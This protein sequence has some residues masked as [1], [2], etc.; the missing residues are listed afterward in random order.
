M[1][2]FLFEKCFP[3][4][5]PLKGL[6]AGA[7]GGKMKR[8]Q[9]FLGVFLAGLFLGLPA[10]AEGPQAR[11]LRADI[12][13]VGAG[14]SGLVAGLSAAE[15]G[16]RVVIF[17]KMP[18]PGGTSNYPAGIFAAES[19][20]QRRKNI[21]V[22]RDDAFRMIM[23]YSHWRANAR[24]VREFVD[25]SA[26]T[27]DWLQKQGVE[28]LE[29]AAISPGGP[30]T[31]HLLKG[32]G[33]AM[34]KV[35]V[36]KAREKGVEIRLAAPVREI[37]KDGQGR[38]SGVLAQDQDGK[39]LKVEAPAVI[40]ATGG[41]A[42]S[43]E[44]IKEYGGFDLGVNLFPAGN[45]GKV[46]EGIK[47]AWAIGA[48]PGG[49]G[50]LQI[51]GGGPVGPGLRP[52]GHLF[53]AASQPYLWINQEGERFC[54]EGIVHNFTF[55]GNA[56]ARQKGGYVFRIFDEM[57]KRYMVEKGIDAALGIS[58]LAATRL[59]DLDEEIKEAREKGNPN[60][61]VADS[62]EELAR[63]MEVNPGVYKRTVE[64]Y[65]RFGEQRNDDLF[66]KDPKYLRPVKT[67]PFYAFKC[68]PTFLGTLGGIKINH[69]TEVLNRAGEV[70]PGLYA[71]GLDAGGMY[72]DSYHL[73]FPGSTIGFAVNSGRIAAE[74][75]LRYLG[76]PP[77]PLRK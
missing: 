55:A 14:A 62:L 72:G 10:A 61:L 75:A 47:M 23:E 11:V 41:Y 32:R 44:M 21:R 35:L 52:G 3:V 9:I 6:A 65:N 1:E 50:V 20:M 4:V 34:V 53:A 19:E 57:T 13:T 24:L 33:A 2:F 37:T 66:A 12:V 64:E 71:V 76:K 67:P 56:V 22:T 15:G 31:W 68:Y 8:V 58:V 5:T 40:I 45:V 70:I 54:D 43:R 46:G 7:K 17:E 51:T 73:I 25:H 77:S 27:I 16:A 42:N 29:P 63:K 60:V 28:F 59:H 30:Q 38:V 26:G 69:R 39:T 49:M 74:N 48:A 18:F 36:A